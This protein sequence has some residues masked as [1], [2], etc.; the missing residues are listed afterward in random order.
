M[1][2]LRQYIEIQE[3][4]NERPV[5]HQFGKGYQVEGYPEYYIQFT[6]DE[7]NPEVYH[8][9]D[10]IHPLCQYAAYWD[11]DDALHYDD[12]IIYR[13]NLYAQYANVPEITDEEYEVI[14]SDKFINAIFND[15]VPR[16]PVGEFKK[17]M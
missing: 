2:S 13:E 8:D 10:F 6:A 7:T 5:K 11:R 16:I 17:N 12:E 14:E 15:T 1:K 3:S 4:L 9:T